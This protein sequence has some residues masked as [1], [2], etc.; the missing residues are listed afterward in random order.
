MALSTTQVLE[1]HQNSVIYSFVFLH[2][3]MSENDKSVPFIVFDF[4]MKRGKRDTL[5]F[6]KKE[7]PRFCI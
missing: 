4:H 3:L 6:F 7:I 1:K 5:S 2:S